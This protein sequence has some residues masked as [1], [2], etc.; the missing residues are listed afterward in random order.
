MDSGGGGDT[1]LFTRITFLWQNIIKIIISGKIL[2]HMV[3][4]GK[5][6]WSCNHNKSMK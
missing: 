2:T 6:K 1:V 3:L 4:K 5:K